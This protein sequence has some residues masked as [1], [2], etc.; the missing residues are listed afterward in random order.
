MTAKRILFVT[1][2]GDV[3]TDLVAE[4]LLERGERPFRI[5]LDEFPRDYSITYE[6]FQGCWE[7][8]IT[9]LPSM[10]TVNADE[11]GAVWLR[12]SS[13]FAFLSD[14]LEEN[15]KNFAV[16]ETEHFLHGFLL[17]LDCYWM[18][19]PV[20]LRSA[21]WKGE[22]LF[23]ANKMGFLIPASI[24]SNQPHAVRSFKSKVN[25]HIIY[26]TMSSPHLST[27]EN[28]V[29]T[30]VSTTLITEKHLAHLDTVAEVPCCFQALVAKSF[31]VRVY[32]IGEAL[33]AAKI[34][35]QDDQ[36]TRIDYRDFS[37]D[38]RYEATQLPINV[39]RFCREFIL[40]YNLNYGA[41]DLIVTPD[42]D[43][44]FLENNPGGQFLFVEQL[45][46]ELNMVETMTD[47]LM[48]AANRGQ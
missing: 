46:P 7:R 27:D 6:F 18:S 41:I 20:A 22:Q 13:D 16:N 39:E 21:Q 34:H 37:A 15:E 29:A 42:G 28:N 45:V 25:D 17:S 4:K 1:K 26:K 19:H 48:G 40:S 30:S 2:S 47:C 35:S 12:K 33:F 31:E 44:V 36:R 14:D 8:S 5:N 3:H 9:Y 11:I 43:Y 38:I 10:D 23:R 24:I 32:V